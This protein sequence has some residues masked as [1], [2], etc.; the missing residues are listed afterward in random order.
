MNLRDLLSYLQFYKLQLTR[1][2]QFF[3]SRKLSWIEFLENWK[4]LFSLLVEI[5]LVG[6]TWPIENKGYNPI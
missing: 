3:Y 5:F 6:S 2:F 4:I 1:R